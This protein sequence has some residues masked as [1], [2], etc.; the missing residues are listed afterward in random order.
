MDFSRIKLKRIYIVNFDPVNRPEFNGEHLALVLKK[1]NDKKTCIV[2]PL[3]SG[4]N[5]EG[6]NKINIGKIST[7]P[8]NLI[9]R[10]SY[11]VYDQVRTVHIDRFK[12]LKNGQAY[13]DAV[14]EDELFFKLLDLGTK[15]MLYGLNLDERILFHKKQYEKSYIDKMIDLAYRI[16]KLEK[17]DNESDSLIESIKSEIMEILR[18]D[19]EYILTEQ[20]ISD[21]IKNVLD[22]IEI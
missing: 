21:G 11:A 18:M 4:A 13:V 3:T 20:Q 12:P 9:V 17:Q 16:I 14:V 7:L 6:A 22:S 10:D 1:N 15:E 5:G 19:I 8:P 2:I